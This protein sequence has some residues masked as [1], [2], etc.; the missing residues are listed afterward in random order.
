MT[1]AISAERCRLCGGR[2]ELLFHK[3]V[4]HSHDV[5]YRE[6]A[7][8]GSLQTDRPY[9]LTEAYAKSNLTAADAGAVGRSLCCQAYV[10]AVARI[11]KLQ[12]ASVLDFGGGNGLLCRLLRD[13]GLDARVFDAFAS[14]DFAQSFADDGSSR[15]DIVCAFEV[16][17]HFANPAEDLQSLFGRAM[18]LVIIGTAP[19]KRQ[20][21]EWWYLN[22]AGGQHVFFY[23]PQAMEYIARQFGFHYRF[24]GDNHL[25]FK[26]R[27]TA[28]QR[29]LLAFAL[30]KR[31][32]KCV[33]AYLGYRLSFAAAERDSKLFPPPAAS[34]EPTINS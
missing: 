8:C 33:R 27:P 5:G 1:S 31:V 21:P 17:E 11:L 24:M 23:A 14:N 13:V 18:Q 19:Y 12:R 7:S 30:S 32:L 34:G 29:R 15:Y 9:W 28:L 25:F 20:G 6:C 4:L 10:Y 2:T 22:P 3:K 26:R 16:A